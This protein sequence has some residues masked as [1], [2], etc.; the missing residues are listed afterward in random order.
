MGQCSAS[1]AWG[2]DTRRFRARDRSYAVGVLNQ[3]TVTAN[4]RQTVPSAKYAA[5]HTTRLAASVGFSIRRLMSRSMKFLQLNL[6]KQR[7]VQH[8]VMND[9]NLKEYAALIIS[10]RYVIEMNGKVTTSPI[11]HQGRT[12]IPP[13]ERHDRRWAVRSML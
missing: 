9:A 10:E 5:D 12:A 13:S 7:N 3:A 4:A 11:G 8:S 6:Q 1:N 2:S